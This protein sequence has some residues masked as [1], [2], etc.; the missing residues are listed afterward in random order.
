MAPMQIE[1]LNSHIE[2]LNR[3]LAA[4]FERAETLTP[5]QMSAC[6]WAAL[7]MP[8]A[9]DA[10]DD[11]QQGLIDRLEQ[12]RQAAHTRGLG[13]LFGWCMAGAQAAAMGYIE[14][15]DSPPFPPSLISDRLRE[16][17]PPP[18]DVL[19]VAAGTGRYSLLLAEE[20]YSVSL[21]DPTAGFLKLAAANALTHG[22]TDR[23]DALLCGA[24]ADL[25]A[26][27]NDAYDACLCI[28]SIYYLPSPHDVERA[29]SQLARIASNCTVFDVPSKLGTIL[30]MGT[31]DSELRFSPSA[32]EQILTTGITPPAKPE[33]GRVIYSCFSAAELRRLVEAAGMQLQQLVGVGPSANDTPDILAQL[34]AQ[35]RTQI[36]GLL[37]SDDAT[38]DCAPCLLAV[39]TRAN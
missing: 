13:L 28:G 11:A 4:A 14:W 21:L 24:F 37:T 9:A 1:Y 3:E 39:C 31:D 8:G 18:G 7:D 30:Q 22:L 6:R 19:D 20:G 26:L 16:I 32:V 25:P 12:A 38:V 34:G 35:Q 33:N 10:P 17:A 27:P 29:V 15:G 23:V 5:E 2:E 36:D